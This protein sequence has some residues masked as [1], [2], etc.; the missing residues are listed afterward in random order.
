[1]G[2]AFL[3]RF[4]GAEVTE[5]VRLHV[6]AKRYLCATRPEYFGGLSPAS[7]H[8]LRLQGGPMTTDEV[9]AFEAEPHYRDAVSVRVY[10]DRAKEPAAKTPDLD[11]YLAIAGQLVR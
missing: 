5:P 10:D 11:H 9:T 2:E 1:L 4:F 8:S 7:V 3:K 6:A